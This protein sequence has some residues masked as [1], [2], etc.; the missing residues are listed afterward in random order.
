MLPLPP[1]SGAD[2]VDVQGNARV[3]AASRWRI[4]AS[5]PGEYTL[6]PSGSPKGSLVSDGAGGYVLTI[7]DLT[8]SGEFVQLGSGDLTIL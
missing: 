6:A 4:V 5:G 3:G 1:P 8:G 2:A 7:G